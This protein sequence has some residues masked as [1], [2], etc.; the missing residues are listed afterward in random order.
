ML[1][2][3]IVRAGKDCENPNSRLFTPPDPFK[4]NPMLGETFED[5]RMKFIAEKTRH[6]PVEFAYHA[7]GPGWELTATSAGKTKFWGE[8]IC[9]CLNKSR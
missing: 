2:H 7:E 8:L 9:R 1:T 6:N 4:S 5:E 3:N